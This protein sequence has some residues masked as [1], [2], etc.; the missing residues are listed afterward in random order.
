MNLWIRSQD[1][2]TL[3]LINTITIAENDNVII[4]YGAD[5][6]MKVLL[7]GYETRERCVEVLDEIQNKIATLNYQNHFLNEDFNLIESNI[8]EMP[9]ENRI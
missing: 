3:M 1:R 4:G 5:N 9:K 2:E 7:G 8:Y 6:N